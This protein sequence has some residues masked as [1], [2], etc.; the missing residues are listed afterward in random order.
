MGTAARFLKAIK[1]DVETGKN[2]PDCRN[3]IVSSSMNGIAA[4]F[5]MTAES[6]D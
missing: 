2:I 1:H 5:R 3:E 6:A 4:A